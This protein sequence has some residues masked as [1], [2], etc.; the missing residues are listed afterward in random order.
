MNRIQKIPHRTTF[1]AHRS[2][3]SGYRLHWQEYAEKTSYYRWVFCV[4]C[5]GEQETG[6]FNFLRVR[7]LQHKTCRYTIKQD[8]FEV[9]S[10]IK[11]IIIIIINVVGRSHWPS[12]LR[13]GTP[14]SRLAGLRVRIPPG[15][16][17]SVS[18]ECCVLSSR[19]LCIRLIIRPEESYRVWCVLVIV[20]PRQWRGL[21]PLRTVEP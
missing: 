19:G 1:F 2:N 6:K 5:D 3:S 20:K 12:G 15:A 17:M 10:S 21:G 9:S 8:Y 14:A 7:V 11:I 13:R 4:L 18:C 16:W